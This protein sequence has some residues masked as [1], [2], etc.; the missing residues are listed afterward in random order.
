MCLAAFA[1]HAS[2]RWPL[3][4]ASN[5]DE[6]FDRPSLPL[7][8][9]QGTSGAS[10][11]SGRDGRAGGTWLGMT[12]AGR[13]A[14]LTN[15]REPSVTPPASHAKSR[16]ELVLRWLEGNLDVAEFMQGIDCLAYGGFNLVLG[17]W[18]TASWN[19]LS[20]RDTEAEVG[21]VAGYCK[22]AAGWQTRTLPPGVYGLSNASLDTPWPK[23]SALKNAL[24]DTLHAASHG[25][26]AT[27]P[28]ASLW[29]ALAN[30]QPAAPENMPATG[31]APDWERA[32]SSAFVDAPERRYGT[33]SSSLLVVSAAID[34]QRCAVSFAEKTHHRSASDPCPP[35]AEST[36]M[37]RELA[38]WNAGRAPA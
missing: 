26:R 12:A 6:S 34:G 19:W 29:T 5:R 10:I 36:T 37:R 22:P 17:D 32:L 28:E 18:S 7:A 1:I 30:R 24:S 11:L 20:N 4:I 3:V 25:V 33:R 9:W 31:L 8:R 2:E 38:E 15:V 14:L 16:G 23:T 35:G 21:A 13:V 27:F